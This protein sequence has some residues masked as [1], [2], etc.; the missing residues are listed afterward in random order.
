MWIVGVDLGGSKV[1][2]ILARRD[3]V[4]STFRGEG[5]NRQVVGEELVVI[6]LCEMVNY[7]LRNHGLV[8]VD[9]LVV[10]G[11]GLGRSREQKSLEHALYGHDIADKVIVRSDAEIALWG[12]LSG[13]P[14]V[15]VIA[16]TGSIV[17]GMN[18]RGRLFRAGGYGYVIGDDGSG[19]W[20]GREGLRAAIAAYEGWGPETALKELALKWFTVRQMEDIIPKIYSDISPQRVLSSFAIAVIQL[21][22]NGDEVAREIVENGAARLAR[23]TVSLLKKL[24]LKKARHLR[25]TGGIFKDKIFREKFMADVKA[26][27]PKIDIAPAEHPPAYGAVL[28]GLSYAKEENAKKSKK[29]RS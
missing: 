29:S 9:M 26:A 20:I 19:F 21:A 5:L 4:V 12:A 24:R 15:V 6:K 11:A 10:G 14:G 1:E 18:E 7:V 25:I 17:F 8:R 16:G 22:E 28:L 23:I 3:R 2:V 13:K 27:Y